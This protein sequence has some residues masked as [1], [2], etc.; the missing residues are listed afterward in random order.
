MDVPTQMAV[1]R[2]RQIRTADGA[3][4]KTIAAITEHAYG[5]LVIRFSDDT[6]V[7]TRLDRGY[8]GDVGVEIDTSDPD[9]SD[10]VDIVIPHPVYDAIV[11]HERAER[12]AQHAAWKRQEYEKLKAEFE[13]RGTTQ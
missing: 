4:G 12:D 5:P 8:D 9:W 13:P 11:A 10:L 3:I 2:E 6:Y 7:I 1:I